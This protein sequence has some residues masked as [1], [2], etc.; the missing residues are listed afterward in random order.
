MIYFRG[1]KEK[2]LMFHFQNSN[3]ADMLANL[4]NQSAQK[5]NVG[6]DDQRTEM[7]MES[8]KLS[9]LLI[10]DDIPELSDYQA[11][12][13]EQLPKNQK[14]Y[15]W[16]IQSQNIALGLGK[17]VLADFQRPI[18]LEMLLLPDA[19]MWVKTFISQILL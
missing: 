3:T 16:L 5:A 18:E 12:G 8:F 7:A 17:P 4:V 6:L 2:K 10:L 15:E 14:F 19:I 1:V 11:V 13:R 9:Q